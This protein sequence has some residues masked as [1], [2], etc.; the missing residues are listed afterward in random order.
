MRETRLRASGLLTPTP[1]GPRVTVSLDTV[2]LR[3]DASGRVTGS[4][5]STGSVADEAAKDVAVLLTDVA[6]RIGATVDG[7]QSAVATVDEW[8]DGAGLPVARR[9]DLLARVETAGG[10]VLLGT[11][12]YGEPSGLV[13]ALPWGDLAGLA[14]APDAGPPDDWRQRPLVLSAAP[15]AVLVAGAAFSLTSRGGRETAQRLAGRRVLPAL[16]VRDLPAAPPGHDRDDLGNPAETRTLVDAGRICPPPPWHEG[17]PRGRAVWDHDAAACG[18]PPLARLDLTGPD[19]A[20]PSG[21]VELLWCVEGLQRYHG[22]GTVR[23]R[24]V[25]RTTDRPDDRFLVVLRGRPI[26]LLRQARGLAGSR[27]AVYSDSDVTT[28]SLVLASA[29]ELE[30]AAHAVVTVRTP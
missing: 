10:P 25:A 30:G 8:R 24:C 14:R 26:H 16:T 2:H 3:R 6:A 17:M 27:T 11:V 12:G 5:R 20:V 18:P 29:A 22:D 9:G 19:L 4:R 21:A 23:L 1:A 13:P 7:L 15:T 28:R